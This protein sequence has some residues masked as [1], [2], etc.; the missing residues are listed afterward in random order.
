MNLEKEQA[1]LV[2]GLTH[3]IYGQASLAFSTMDHFLGRQEASKQFGLAVEHALHKTFDDFMSK[4][5]EKDLEDVMQ[6]RINAQ[7]RSAEHVCKLAVAIAARRPECMQELVSCCARMAS[8]LTG[9][10]EHF[11]WV[12]ENDLMENGKEI[13]YFYQI[14]TEQKCFLGSLALR[15][16]LDAGNVPFDSQMERDFVKGIGEVFDFKTQ[17]FTAFGK[18]AFIEKSDYFM[19]CHMDISFSCYAK[20]DFF[21]RMSAVAEA[22]EIEA[23]VGK[24]RK[25]SSSKPQPSSPPR[26]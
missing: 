2:E 6:Q 17:K 4:P 21:D 14:D 13:P 26:V 12:E 16:Q 25:I 11:E 1:D 23:S 15:Q 18:K 5:D 19:S 10:E 7:A 3:S 8:S 9:A 22:F 20:P 24:K